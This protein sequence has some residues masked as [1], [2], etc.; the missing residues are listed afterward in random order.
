[1]PVNENEQ[2]IREIEEVLDAGIKRVGVD[3][4]STEFDLAVLQKRLEE[5][6]RQDNVTRRPAI[7]RLLLDNSF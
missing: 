2:V 6:R 5:R 4:L 1:M 7:T 3:G